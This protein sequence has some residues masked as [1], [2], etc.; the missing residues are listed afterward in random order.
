MYNLRIPEIDSGKFTV[1]RCIADLLRAI[2]STRRGVSEWEAIEFCKK[3]LTF[4]Q[5]T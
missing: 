4:K 5:I 1:R 2:V 3:I